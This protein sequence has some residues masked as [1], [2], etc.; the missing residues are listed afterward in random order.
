MSEFKRDGFENL[1]EVIHP[2]LEIEQVDKGLKQTLARLWGWNYLKGRFQKLICDVDGRLMVSSDATKADAANQSVVI[3]PVG[4]IGV[5]AAN[6]QRRQVIIQNVGAADAH[7]VFGNAAALSPAMVLKPNVAFTDDIYVGAIVA[8]TSAGV[9][10][11]EVTE[12]TTTI[13]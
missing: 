10:N 11:L 3:V 8:M 4:G 1:G 9:T 7:I 2:P 13:D 5:L 6:P 12:M